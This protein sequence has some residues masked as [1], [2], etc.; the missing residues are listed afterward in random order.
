MDDWQADGH[1]IDQEADNFAA[2]LLMP[3]GDFR[4]QILNTVDFG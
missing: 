3:L 1:R 4:K 2:N